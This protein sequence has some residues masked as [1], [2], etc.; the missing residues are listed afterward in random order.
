MNTRSQAA[1]L[2]SQPLMSTETFEELMEIS[3]VPH[4]KDAKRLFGHSGAS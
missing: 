1:N 3:Q 4:E 2:P